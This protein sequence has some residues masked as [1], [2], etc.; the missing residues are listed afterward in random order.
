MIRIV[1]LS[2]PHFGTEPDGLPSVLVAYLVNLAPDL[3][4]LSGDL[5][6]RALSAQ[7]RA[8]RRFIAELPA[9][10][11]V[12][13]GNHD[14]PLWNLPLRLIDPW[15]P[16]HDHLGCPLEGR[17]ETEKVV[18]VGLNSA[19][20]RVWKDGLITP[21]QCVGL[22]R[23]FADAGM[24]RRILALHH[25]P[26]PPEGEAPSLV[27]ADALID[28]CE[29]QGVEMVLSG[30]LH[31]TQIAPITPTMLGVQTGTC[32]SSRIRGDGNAFTLLDLQPDGVAV[33]HHRLATDGTFVADAVTVWQ[34][35]AG[36]WR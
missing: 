6:Q 22:A 31:F 20:P 19:N 18:I 35:E 12:L 26:K 29:A 36:L 1:H 30:H 27:G 34:R 5:T 25:P 16:W 4:V 9:P 21:V 13:P 10:T 2:D 33:S 24:R 11:L 15:R 3:I 23:A 14:A 17:I 8:A 28:A 7:F 32:L